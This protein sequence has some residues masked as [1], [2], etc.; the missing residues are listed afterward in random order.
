MILTYYLAAW[1]G[2]LLLALLLIKVF[3]GA[4]VYRR[5]R[6]RRLVTCPETRKPAAVTVDASKAGVSAALGEARLRIQECSRWPA[7]KP[8]HAERRRCGQH[9]LAQIEAAPDDCLIKTMV[10]RWYAEKNCVFCQS[11]IGE[12]D[13]LGQKPALMRPDRNTVQWDGITAEHLPEVLA[14]SQPV[15]WNCHVAE[16]FRRQH[17]ELVVDRSPNAATASGSEIEPIPASAALVTPAPALAAD[18][19]HTQADDILTWGE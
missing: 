15:C 13:W 10:T 18:Q 16:S 19:K 7:L 5:F 11:S 4:A 2:A 9:C 1:L 14:S 3:R 8:G 6:G 17:P 12:V